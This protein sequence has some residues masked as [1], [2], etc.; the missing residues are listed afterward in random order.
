MKTNIIYLEQT[1]STNRYLHENHSELSTDGM[2]VVWT[3]YQTAGK[4][5]GENVW[6]SERGKNLLFSILIHPVS[7][8]VNKQFVLS[9]AIALAVR[10][11]LEQ[12]TDNLKV[13]WP[14]DIY[15]HD[16]KISGILIENTITSNGISDCIIGIGIDINQVDF[17][18]KTISPVS[19]YN[20]L[21]REINP[22]EVMDVV[23]DKFSEYLL[24]IYKGDYTDIRMEYLE[25]LYRRQGQHRFSDA[26]GKFVA[27]ID[28]I[29][30]DGHLLLRDVDNNIRR[31]AFKEVKYIL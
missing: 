6:E 8:S 21:G 13:K 24:F 16:N 22:K 28:G 10:N 1:D 2:T 27:S 20:I 15:W 3:K 17:H 9:M 23:I 18:C 7:V 26:K 30:D 14:N 29:E 19:L 12:Y 31:Y 25:S 5:Q 11:T 4:G